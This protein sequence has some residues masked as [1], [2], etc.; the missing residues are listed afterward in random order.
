MATWNPWTQLEAL[1][2]DVDRAFANAEFHN[3]PFFRTA[4]EPGQA[5]RRYP[6][7]SQRTPITCTSRPWH[8]ALIQ[9]LLR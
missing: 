6:L 4:F 7:I 2:R 8:Q 1:R 9:A 5:A 3:R